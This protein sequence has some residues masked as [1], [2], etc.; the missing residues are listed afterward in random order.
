MGWW[1]IVDYSIEDN[2]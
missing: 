2:L 1:A